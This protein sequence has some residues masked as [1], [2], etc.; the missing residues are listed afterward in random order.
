MIEYGINQG[1]EV[2][3]ALGYIPLPKNVRERIAA[4]ADGISP[5][6]TITVK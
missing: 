6:Y 2:A 4:A 1:Q 3:G 5:D